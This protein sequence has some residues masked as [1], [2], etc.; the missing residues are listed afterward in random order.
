MIVPKFPNPAEIALA[1]E[2][3]EAILADKKINTY[4][5]KPLKEGYNEC[6]R[7]LKERLINPDNQFFVADQEDE[8]EAAGNIYREQM[9]PIKELKTEIGRT[10]AVLCNDFL[11]GQSDEQTFLDESFFKNSE[12]AAQRIMDKL[13]KDANKPTKEV[14]D[15]G[16]KDLLSNDG[17]R[18]TALMDNQFKMAG[19][20][21]VVEGSVFLEQDKENDEV[22][23][24]YYWAINDGSQAI[25]DFMG[26]SDFK[27][28]PIEG[29]YD[30]SE[31]ES[32]GVNGEKIN[33]FSE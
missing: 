13:L 30:T 32:E 12:K 24:D 23:K 8:L 29:Y 17:Q 14:V 25:L 4:K 27:V 21:R 31:G 6:L 28:L 2:K 16:I 1:I 10:I 11:N 33:E 7:M 20:I 5:N 18:Y 22:P 3:V 15:N 19:T 26:I 9:L